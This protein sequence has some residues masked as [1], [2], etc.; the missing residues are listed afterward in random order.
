MQKQLKFTILIHCI[1]NFQNLFF[2]DDDD[3]DD[4]C[5]LFVDALPNVSDQSSY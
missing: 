3:D 1:N 2:D 4:D 5:D